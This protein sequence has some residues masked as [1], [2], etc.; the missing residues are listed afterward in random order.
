MDEDALCNAAKAPTS[1]GS[2]SK[3]SRLLPGADIAP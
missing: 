2:P 1:A 3:F